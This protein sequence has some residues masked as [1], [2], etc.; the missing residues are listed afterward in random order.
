MS[1][2][3]ARFSGLVLVR[4]FYSH[5]IPLAV[6]IAHGYSTS[7][8]SSGSAEGPVMF[9]RATKEHTTG[10]A[11]PLQPNSARSNGIAQSKPPSPSVGVKR[12]LEMADSGTSTLGSL[13]N[14]VYFDEDDFADDD[15]LDFNEPDPFAV[16]KKAAS[17]TPQPALVEY[18][19]TNGALSRASIPN[20]EESPT[21]MDDSADVKYPDLPPIP[22]DGGAPPSTIQ[23]PWSSSPPSH[24]QPPPKR[25]TLPWKKKEE[26]E[27]EEHRR[28]MTTPARPKATLPWNKS[29]SAIKEEQKELRRQSKNQKSDANSKKYQPRPKIASIFLSDEQRG[30]LEAVSNQGK[31]IFFTGSAGTGKSVL[32][33]EIISTLRRKYEREKD[34]VAVTASTGLAA[35]NIE[36]VTL[37]SFA[38]IG[39]GKDPVPELVKKVIPLFASV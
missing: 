31:S 29:A 7:S 3:R 23:Y 36:G 9:H 20:G 38:G 16:P 39:L 1:A 26:V 33:R 11:R 8:R 4:Q 14:A 2:S 35:C 34:R 25:R 22:D 21:P 18:P 5:G 30:V 27:A 17:E 12:K 15:E 13:H 6:P 19:N 10:P 32:M 24:F 37:H 28:M